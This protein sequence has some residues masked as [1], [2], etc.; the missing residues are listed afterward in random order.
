MEL[1][2]DRLFN[3]AAKFS[4]PPG[5]RFA[6]GTAGFRTD[7]SLLDSTTFS[8]GVLAALRSLFT[9]SAIG[10]MITASHNPV[11]DNGVKIADPNGDMLSQDWEPFAESLANANSPQ[12]FL[13]VVKDFVHKNG[14]FRTGFSCGRVLLARDTRPSGEKLM[15][16][17]RQ[18]VEAVAG[19]NV[20]VIGILTTPQ[21][22]WMVR[23]CN[24]GLGASERD[25]FCELSHGFRCL[26]DMK[27]VGKGLITSPDGFIVDGANGVGASKLLELQCLVQ[28]LKLD[29]RNRGTEGEGLLNELVGADFVQKE[30]KFPCGF[31]HSRELGRR[32]ASLD[33]DADRIVFFY[34]EQAEGAQAESLQL[35][36]GD[37][38]LTL[39]AVFIQ[40]QVQELCRDSNGPTDNISSIK[41]GVVQTA[42]ANGASTRFLKEKLGI[43]VALTAT[44][45]KHLHHKAAEYDIGLYF[46]A[47]GHGTVLFKEEFLQ[48]LKKS[49]PSES[50]SNRVMEEPWKAAQRLLAV[51]ELVNQAIG[52]A[53]SVLLLV[54]V[55]LQYMGW[56][57]Q[58]WNSIYTD[59]PSRQL[60][61]K[62]QD[63]TLI[64]T[65]NAE[66]RVTHPPGLQAAI[67]REVGKVRLGRAFVRPS[68][69]E[70]I[71]RVYAEAET[72]DEANILARAIAVH[73]HELANSV[74]A[75]P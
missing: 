3:A 61:V 13:Q 10:L 44:G 40:Q 65:T 60:K 66:T 28:E 33:G 6:Y 70:D 27:P 50:S 9:G 24:R 62:V 7:A 20:V 57:V 2:A 75:S 23:A 52:D 46:E 30:R 36:D 29:I 31:G 64:K 45:V 26:L 17:A 41:L 5:V 68:G 53:L 14:V 8:V 38:I 72:Q 19:V 54:E 73:V 34:G 11:H 51:C 4:P 47:N 48:I 63:R 55:V 18:G 67:D 35:L 21:L 39:F 37:K 42:Y 74:D 15:N 59:L 56:S 58:E 22:H 69:T 32:C 71:V 1:D 16:A 49:Y 25:Y 43:Q 12:I